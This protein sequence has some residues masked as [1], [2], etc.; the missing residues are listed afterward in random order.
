MLK[1]VHS[2]VTQRHLNNQEV[3]MGDLLLAGIE[4]LGDLLTHVRV[5]YTR[6]QLEN[7]LDCVLALCASEGD[8][9]QV[10][11]L[12]RALLAG[13]P[14]DGPVTVA[15]KVCVQCRRSFNPVRDSSVFCSGKCRVMAHRRNR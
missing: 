6:Y 7:D 13:K 12:A 3:M 14:Y 4:P 9:K 5:H 2:V 15:S 1:V 8:R 11:R 10:R